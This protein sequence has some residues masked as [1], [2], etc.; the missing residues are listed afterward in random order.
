MKRQAFIKTGLGIVAGTFLLPRTGFSY[1]NLT[2]DP[3]DK[4]LV[5]KFVKNAHNNF[6]VTKNMLEESPA[7]LHVSHD[8]GD[9]DFETALGAASHTGHRQIVEYLLSKGARINI[10]T[11]AML[12]ELEI[13]KQFLTKYPELANAKG[14]H[15]L[16]LIHHANVGGEPAKPVLEYLKKIASKKANDLPPRKDVVF[17]KNIYEERAVAIVDFI[18]DNGGL[19]I[20]QFIDT[21]FA[22]DFIEKKGRDFFEGVFKKFSDDIPPANVILLESAGPELCKMQ[23]QKTDRSTNFYFKFS[24]TETEPYLINK[25]IG[26]G[27]NIFD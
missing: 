18:H 1:N 24:Y 5:F 27:R 19:T 6:E 8:W 12:G 25:L 3:L 11:A 17:S 9:G 16:S 14:P 20:N 13:I 23:L 22:T 10:F 7:L 15:G 21:H 4:K 2:S 26:S